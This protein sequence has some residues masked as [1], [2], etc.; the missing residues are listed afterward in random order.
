M[1]LITFRGQTFDTDQMINGAPA[2][3]VP[4]TLAY[5][6]N[7]AGRPNSAAPVNNSSALQ[8]Y[9]LSSEAQQ[10]LNSGV[11]AMNVPGTPEY[12]ANQRQAYANSLTTNSIK[13]ITDA[14]GPVKD[15]YPAFSFDEELAK[16]AST[17]EY[18]PYYQESLNNFIK[19][20]QTKLSQEQVSTER[21]LGYISGQET[22][23]NKQD[24]LYRKTVLLDYEN[25]IK[26]A[27]EGYAGGGLSFSGIANK[28]LSDQTQKYQ[29]GLE[30]Y[31]LGQQQQKAG[32]ENQRQGMTSD[33][34]N[35]QSNTQTAIDRQTLDTQ[36]SQQA[37][38]EGGVLQRRGEAL[39]Q[40]KVGQLN[41]YSP[42]LSSS[43]GLT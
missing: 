31:G 12:E 28:G 40:Y 9:G 43:Y 25:A 7:M 42:V 38:I 20:S 11:P 22:T 19:D 36:R 29:T 5:E 14:L 33:L 6:W 16:Q 13:A 10:A 37:A 4:G 41:Y 30:S 35:L 34:A 2:V 39:D 15:S 26:Q 32:I 24:E 3:N 21:G 17:V 27:Q 23:L 1:A 8:S 18:A